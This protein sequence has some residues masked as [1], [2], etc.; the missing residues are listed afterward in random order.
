[1]DTK[2]RII[3]QAEDGD[4]ILQDN[5]FSEERASEYH[6]ELSENY[7]EGQYLFIE[8]YRPEYY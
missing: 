8:E 2:Y 5:I 6:K 7:G 4:Y 3:L 1:M